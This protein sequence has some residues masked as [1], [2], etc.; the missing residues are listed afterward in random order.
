MITK[1]RT[2]YMFYCIDKRTK[3]G[4]AL[5]SRELGKMWR[6]EQHR[7]QWQAQAAQDKL[8]YKEEVALAPYGMIGWQGYKPI[9]EDQLLNNPATIDVQTPSDVWRMR[10]MAVDPNWRK[11]RG[12]T[13]WQVVT[14]H[15]PLFIDQLCAERSPCDHDNNFQLDTRMIACVLQANSVQRAQPGLWEHFQPFF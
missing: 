2:A 3:A 15:G 7:E 14:D 5:N 1:P 11:Q 8:R 12:H 13:Y 10:D 6:A 4:Y 9:A